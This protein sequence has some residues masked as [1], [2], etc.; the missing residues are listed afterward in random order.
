M[1]YM[2]IYT[3]MYVYIYI[4]RY[5]EICVY[6]RIQRETRKIYTRMLSLT[7]MSGWIIDYRLFYFLLFCLYIFSKFST[8]II[9][10]LQRIGCV[11]IKNFKSI[12][13]KLASF[14]QKTS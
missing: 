13:T 4:C 10:T 7:N 5:R 11:L 1:F 14:D 6:T 9:T 3:Y 2:C 8:Y 12:V